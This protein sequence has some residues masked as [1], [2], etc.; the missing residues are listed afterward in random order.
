MLSSKARWLLPSIP[1]S[2]PCPINLPKRHF[3]KNANAGKCNFGLF[4]DIDG[5][6]V[7][8]NKLIEGSKEAFHELLTFDGEFVVPTIFLTNGGGAL[9]STKASQLSE[10]LGVNISADQVVLA[11]SPL[12]SMT[13]LHGKHTLV[14]GQGPLEDICQKLGFSKITTIESLRHLFPLH[15]IVDAE[16]RATAKAPNPDAISFEPVEAV[17]LL[18]D[19]VRWE[20]Q[21]QLIIDALMTNG[22]IG[23]PMTSVPYP[24]LPVVA[25]NADLIWAAQAPLPRIG[26]GSFLHVLE[27]LYAKITGKPLVYEA[28]LGKPSPLTYQYGERVIQSA[29]KRINGPDVLKTLYGIGDNPETDI[30]GANAYNDTIA[31]GGGHGAHACQSILVKSGVFMEEDS[32]FG[33]DVDHQHHTFVD[34]KTLCKPSIVCNNFYDAVQI[35]FQ[36]ENYQ[37]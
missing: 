10:Y 4:V 24:H 6:I 3:S 35:V 5:V 11:H 1:L 34:Y 23:R 20:T 27:S 13:S 22:Y 31:A 28:I 17:V 29:S 14:V 21:M 26:H 33:T 18:G 37:R 9:R 12:R 7:R 19:P 25:C 15:D 30:A 32:N 16:R 8:G 2:K 36:K